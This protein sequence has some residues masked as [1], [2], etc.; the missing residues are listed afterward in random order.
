[1]GQ[2]VKCLTDIT[3][4]NSTTTVSV[5]LTE[6]GDC[7]NVG[8]AVITTTGTTYTI[9]VEMTTGGSDWV[10]LQSAGSDVTVTASEGLVLEPMPFQQLRILATGRSSTHAGA[11]PLTATSTGTRIIVTGGIVV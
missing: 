6:F 8:L 10:D 11:L 5:A 1:M 9:Q 4:I 2:Y 7:R 3:F